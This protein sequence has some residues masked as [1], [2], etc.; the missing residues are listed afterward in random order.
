MAKSVTRLSAHT[1]VEAIR[2]LMDLGL[3]RSGRTALLD[4]LVLK[5]RETAPESEI[6]IRALGPESVQPQLDR[7]FA[8]APG[9]PFPYVNP[10]GTREGRLEWLAAEYERRGTYTHLYEGR[11]FRL[12]LG[13]FV[14]FRR[15]DSYAAVRIDAGAAKHISEKLGRKIP[16]EPAAAFLLRRE[17]FTPQPDRQE[18]VDRLRELFNL[19][20]S[21]L[22]A[23]FEPVPGF[24]LGFDSVGFLESLSSLPPDLH[25]PPPEKGHATSSTTASDVA[26]VKPVD[27]SDL[28][29][30]TVLLRRSRRALLT[31]QAIAFVGPP[32]TGK[33]RLIVK[34]IEEARADPASF[35][36]SAAPEYELYAAEADWTG[37]TLVGGYFPQPDGVLRFQEG[38]LLRALRRNRWLVIDEMNRADLDRVMG[39]VLTLLAGQHVDLGMSELSASGIPMLLAWGAEPES[40]VVEEQG[41]RIY[42]AGTDWRVLGTYNSVDLGRVFSMGA[43][44]S[45]RWATVPVPPLGEDDIGQLL[46]ARGFPAGVVALIRHLYALH[47]RYL[48]LGPAPFLDAVSFAASTPMEV[49]PGAAP[50][51]VSPETMDLLRDAYVLYFAPQLRRMDPEHR[52]AFMSELGALLGD[53]LAEEL[54]RG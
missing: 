16:L 36:L 11:A 14:R 26:P 31:S 50:E 40:G 42:V 46:E 44:L 19:S 22:E 47:L 28:V 39:P 33:S 17:G 32:G 48:P 18:L 41:Q 30:S 10:F 45:R 4:Y 27:T 43:A 15:S 54:R 8:L 38:Y 51:A 2:T 49:G 35:E 6:R 7:F 53:A 1:V 37:R 21:E 20:E 25:P 24:A 29:V 52:D 34:L 9:S 23:L 3:D 12:Y 5:A 13:S